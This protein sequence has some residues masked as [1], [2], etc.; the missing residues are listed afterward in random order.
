MHTSDTI[1]QQAI[2]TLVARQ[3]LS[4]DEARATMA[5]IMSGKASPA[6][7]GG[8]LVAARMK[9]ETPD[10]IAGYADAMRAVAHTVTIDHNAYAVDTCGT[11]GDQKDT[12]NIST[13]AAFVIAGCDVIVAKHGNRAVSS[14]CGSADVLRALGVCIDLTPQHV[15][16]CF[17]SLGIAFLFAPTFHPAMQYAGPV[18]KELGVRSVFNILGPLTNPAGVKN[19]IIGVYDKWLVEPIAHV[20]KK[21][22][23][24][25]VF[26]VH[27]EDGLDELTITGKTFV[28][29]LNH[30]I[31]GLFIIE[32]AQYGFT[33]C[34]LADIRGG[35]A[36]QNAMMIQAIV[37]GQKGPWRDIV[38]LNAG[39]ALYASGKYPDI[40]AGIEAA[41]Y[42]IDSG[43]ARR[44]LE[45]L[46]EYTQQYAV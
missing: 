16:D 33:Q 27:G 5:H 23:S 22:G 2:K 29:E 12:F 35:D 24:R 30:G 20:L 34:T 4:F 18:R 40:S 15:E 9:G 31:V 10:E 45:Q 41:R 38:L 42:S 25:H 44:K 46:R 11:G 7:I 8:F 39:V 28:A 26:V 1:I 37:N 14:G 32:P 17:K 36:A 3:S 6:Q 21:L 19:Q 43:A 13:A